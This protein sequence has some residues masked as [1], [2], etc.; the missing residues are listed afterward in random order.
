MKQEKN[1]QIVP[2]CCLVALDHSC[3]RPTYGRHDKRLKRA[4]RQRPLNNLGALSSQSTSTEVEQKQSDP[5]LEKSGAGPLGPAL[6]LV[7]VEAFPVP[8][9]PTVVVDASSSRRRRRLL[10]E[11]LQRQNF[12][13]TKDEY[14]C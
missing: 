3:K 2:L 11:A 1:R 4:N 14:N 13:E 8:D 12:D 10:A 6:E 5:L 7:G 9:L